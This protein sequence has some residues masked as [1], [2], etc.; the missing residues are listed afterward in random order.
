MT[1][2]LK[3]KRILVKLDDKLVE[4][5]FPGKGRI[6][7]RPVSDDEVFDATVVEGKTLDEVLSTQFQQVVDA[8]GA[9]IREIFKKQ[10]KSLAIKSLG[11]DNSWGE[12]RVDHGNGR[13]SIVS[14]HISQKAKDLFRI[15][16]DEVLQKDMQLV[17]KQVTP[18]LRK[19]FKEVFMQEVRYKIR[20]RAQAAAQDFLK[21]LVTNALEKCKPQVEQQAVAALLGVQ[22]V[23]RAEESDEESWAGADPTDES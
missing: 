6:D 5:T 20:E 7:E 3:N 13:H 1:T 4:L 8:T 2:S 10:V 18:A 17:I 23:E 9:E 16:V 11:F 15:E 12:L 14:E 22:V 19:E 21:T